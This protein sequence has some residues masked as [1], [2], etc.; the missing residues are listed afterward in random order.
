MLA[1]GTD[2][3]NHSGGGETLDKLEYDTVATAFQHMLVSR[4]LADDVIPTLD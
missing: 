3:F 1:I 2:A 4:Y